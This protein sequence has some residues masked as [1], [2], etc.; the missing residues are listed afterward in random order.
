MGDTRSR[1]RK[2]GSAAVAR[3]PTIDAGI[4][5]R[6]PRTARVLVCLDPRL[7]GV[8]MRTHGTGVPVATVIHRSA[9]TCQGRRLADLWVDLSVDGLR[10]YVARVGGKQGPRQ[11]SECFRMFAGRASE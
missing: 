6:H 9:A 7:A 8:E 5:S 2:T 10:G 4:P 11:V 1:E 3:D